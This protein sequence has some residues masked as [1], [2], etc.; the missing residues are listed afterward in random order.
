[1]EITAKKKPEPHEVAD[2]AN[3]W[4]LRVQTLP[5]LRDQTPEHALENILVLLPVDLILLQLLQFLFIHIE[6]QMLAHVSDILLQIPLIILTDMSS[7][8]DLTCPDLFPLKK[9]PNYAII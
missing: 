7:Q 9:K 4:V 1:M 6:I 2:D 3:Q 8:F 5:M